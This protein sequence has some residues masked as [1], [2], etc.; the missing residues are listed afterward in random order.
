[1][2]KENSLTERQVQYVKTAARFGSDGKGAAESLCIEHRTF[3]NGIRKVAKNLGLSPG[4]P[5]GTLK[6]QIIRI[7][8]KHGYLTQEYLKECSDNFTRRK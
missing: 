3:V 6:I 2:S 4:K 8:L 5:N 7:G 1:M